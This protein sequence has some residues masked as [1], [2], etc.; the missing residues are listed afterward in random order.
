V[1]FTSALSP[2][3]KLIATAAKSVTLRDAAT[4]KQIGKP[5][6]HGEEE[7]LS[8]T[9]SP[10]SKQLATITYGGAVRLWDSASHELV[11]KLPSERY[12]S[13]DVRPAIAFSSDGKKLALAYGA[14]LGLWDWALRK[15]L[16][17][18]DIASQYIFRAMAIS[19]AGVIAFSSSDGKV[20]LLDAN[21]FAVEELKAGPTNS[22]AFSPD[23]KILATGGDDGILRLWDWASRR[24]LITLRGHPDVI[25]SI[26]FSPDG[27]KLAS[28]DFNMLRVWHAPDPATPLERKPA[29]P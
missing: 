10:D 16:H 15:Q 24:E 12:S 17:R 25:M 3:G 9:F 28:W 8:V 4:G 18:H 6:T 26:G 1:G 21:T 13:G 14:D 2:D 5:L 27:K 22:L 20:G 29:G 11:A 19:R 23:G 7:I